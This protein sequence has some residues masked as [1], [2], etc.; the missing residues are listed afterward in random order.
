MA[1]LRWD[2]IVLTAP[3]RAMIGPEDVDGPPTADKRRTERSF[4]AAD[5]TD[6]HLREEII[7]PF[8]VA[9]GG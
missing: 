1:I 7:F 8:N 3:R 4:D 6:K 9:L 2:G 5:C